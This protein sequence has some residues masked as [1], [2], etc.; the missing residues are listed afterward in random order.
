[1]RVQV[2][3]TRL[4]FDIVGDELVP[5]GPGLRER[6]TM[7]CLHGGPG[8]D[9]S[10]LKHY[11]APLSDVAR[12]VFVDQRGQGRSDPST[13]ER[14]NLDRWIDDVR[15]FCDAIEI[16]RPT[17][18]GHSFGGVVALGAAIRHPD[19]A[20]RLVIS[21]SNARFRLDRVL[22]K[23][24]ELGGAKARTVAK[25][26]FAEPGHETFEAFSDTCVPLYSAVTLDA[27][28]AARIRRRPEVAFHFF[29]SA[30]FAYDLSRDL[31]AIRC[32]TL[33]L[34]GRLDPI[35]TVEDQL[36]LHAGIPGS[37]LELVHAAGHGVFRDRPDEALALLRDFVEGG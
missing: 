4:F 30:D 10:E 31:G 6:P 9:H 2:D 33:I 28:V 24:E 8:A 16:V 12:L 22:A 32:P 14:W 35:A 36:E 34:G 25:C 17:I 26:F 21:S 11:L 5:C 13:P 1:M 23:M 3:D 19:L 18:L 15:R 27:D 37:R 29:R 7:V 20:G